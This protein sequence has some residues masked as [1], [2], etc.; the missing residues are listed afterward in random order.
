MNH[1]RATRLTQAMLTVFSLVAFSARQLCAGI[2]P[3]KYG[4]TAAT[5]TYLFEDLTE[6]SINAPPMLGNVDDGAVTIPIGFPFVFYGVWYNAVS[7]TSNGTL[8]FRNVDIDWVPVDISKTAPTNN[9]PMIA[10]LWHDWTFQ[11]FGSD[12]VYAAT[13][14]PSGNRRLIVQWNAALSATGPGT[15]TVTFEVKLFEGSNNIEFH[16]LDPT[17]FDDPT[18]SN[19][20]DAT[21]GIRDT[22]GQVNGRN[23]QWSFDQAIIAD[24]EA[25]QIVAPT[26]NI[27]AITRLTNGHILLQCT[28]A[29]S[30]VN[31]I[32]ATPA[33]STKPFAPLGDAAADA[34]GKFQ[35]EDG[36]APNFTRRFY[37]V[38]VP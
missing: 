22:A 9:L 14:G 1:A 19:G 36:G 18:V 7:V 26:F 8:T 17:V 15:D 10:V 11:Y 33:L 13:L 16:F 32:E 23:L 28:G 2:G 27:S 6:P 24:G 4:Y 31:H 35:Y 20:K 29:P 21:V 34:S 25:I 5:T 12:A 37:R 3:D 30:S 38:A